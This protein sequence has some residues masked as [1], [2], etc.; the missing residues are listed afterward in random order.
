M[1]PR[2][3]LF[4]VAATTALCVSLFLLSW[5]ADAPKKKPKPPPPPPA[6]VFTDGTPWKAVD[7]VAALERAHKVPELIVDVLEESK[8]ERK[9]RLGKNSPNLND[10]KNRYMVLDSPILKDREPFSEIYTPVRF[11]HMKHA[12]IVKD[13]TECHHF[14]PK[15]T[16]AEELVRC[17]A[18]HQNAFDSKVPGRPGLKAAYHQKC[19]GCHQETA[20]GPLGCTGCHAKNVPDH[21]DLVKLP[22]NPKPTD[23]TRECLRCHDDAAE[24][25]LT[26]AHWLWKGPS[27]Y[28]VGGEKRVDMGKATNTI[29][30]FCV[31]L[32]SNW[33]RCTSCHAG[34]GWKDASFDFKDKTRMDC[35][36]CHDTTLKYRKVPTDA[37]LPYPQ[38]D[39]KDIAQRVGKPSRKT[40][41][42][43]HFQGGG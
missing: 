18:C 32:A 30:N 16:K 14:R 26:S 6:M 38:L 5:A 23:V 10:V 9:R 24:D 22:E 36:I 43:C 41:G 11:M 3:L 37:G 2:R 8:W 12:A 15:D 19:M 1:R 27:P 25:M 13:C 33:P 40:C 28:T 21:R 29:N 20:T 39:L 4:P 7:Q 42:D 34:Y 17:S 35:L 31:A